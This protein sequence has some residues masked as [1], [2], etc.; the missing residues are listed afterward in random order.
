MS[1]LEALVAALPKILPIVENITDDLFR[2]RVFDALVEAATT[3][4]TSGPATEPMP[5]GGYGKVLVADPAAPQGVSWRSASNAA[6]GNETGTVYGSLPFPS[7]ETVGGALDVNG[8]RLLLT[9]ANVASVEPPQPGTVYNAVADIDG[10]RIVGTYTGNGVS[11]TF[12]PD[13]HLSPNLTGLY[14]APVLHD[15]IGL[16]AEGNAQVRLETAAGSEPL[17][18]ASDLPT[19]DAVNRQRQGQ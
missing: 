4:A 13:N 5:M 7:V 16:S 18:P 8:N 6:G 2:D 11:G 3:D 15:A 9:P 17:R 1:R 10:S 14:S 19:W 12:T